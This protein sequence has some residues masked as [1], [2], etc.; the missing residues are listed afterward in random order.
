M[1]LWMRFNGKDPRSCRYCAFW[2]GSVYTINSHGK[3]VRIHKGTG[4]VFGCE[5]CPF[6][7]DLEPPP[8]PEPRRVT[9]LL[10]AVAAVSA[11]FCFKGMEELIRNGRIKNNEA[12]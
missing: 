8:P 12:Y 6:V 11:L 5:N 10:I 9:G 3:R 4:C 1:R 2:D 7:N